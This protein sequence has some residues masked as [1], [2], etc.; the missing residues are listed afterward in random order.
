MKLS[1]LIIQLVVVRQTTPMVQRSPTHHSQREYCRRCDFHIMLYIHSF[2][3]R[4]HILGH[5]NMLSFL[6]LS[7]SIS[8]SSVSSS[9]SVS[10]TSVPH[11]VS[12][13]LLFPFRLFQGLLP[14][15]FWKIFLGLGHC[16]VDVEGYRCFHYP[17]PSQH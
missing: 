8:P 13:S 1:F 12:S 2:I 17:K 5:L 15:P 10:S 7:P 6:S 9:G 3:V 14:F 11:S 16:S 4:L